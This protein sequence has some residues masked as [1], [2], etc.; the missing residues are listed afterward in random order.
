[1]EFATD[2]AHER[3]PLRVGSEVGHDRP[4]TLRRRIDLD[5]SAELSHLPRVLHRKALSAA[6]IAL[7]KEYWIP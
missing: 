6:A 5:L 2:P 3:I 4:H 7:D 1:M